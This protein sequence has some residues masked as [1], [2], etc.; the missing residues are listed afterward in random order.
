MHSILERRALGVMTRSE[1]HNY[2]KYKLNHESQM[3]D[4]PRIRQAKTN[5]GDVYTS[6]L[7]RRQPFWEE[8]VTTTLQR[9]VVTL[10][11]KDNTKEKL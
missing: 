2:Y 10:Y 3:T 11:Y 7:Y 9:I 8:E 6:F 1:Y 5:L 4:L